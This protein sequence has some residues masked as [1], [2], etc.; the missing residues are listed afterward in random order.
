MRIFLYLI[1]L[2]LL[3]VSCQS[4]PK[5]ENSKYDYSVKTGETFHIDLK[6]NPSTGYNW[7]WIQ[8]GKASIVVLA[9]KSYQSV[10]KPGIVGAGGVSTFQFKAIGKGRETLHF[11]YIRPW[12]KGAKPA[13]V[14]TFEI[15]VK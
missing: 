4:A 9:D 11:E 12:E 7:Q 3:W 8:N 13:Q 14:A 10:A 2:P 5:A 1:L 6:S 15:E